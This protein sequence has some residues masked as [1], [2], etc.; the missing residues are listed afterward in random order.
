MGI[1]LE[2]EQAAGVVTA[3][4]RGGR[5]RAVARSRAVLLPV[6]LGLGALVLYISGQIGGAT[7]LLAGFSIA[8]VSFTAVVFR[9]RPGDE[10]QHE[11]AE[12]SPGGGDGPER[13]ASGGES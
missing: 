12:T 9:E 4:Q 11:A 6:V 10:A 7:T 2:Y 1:A 3:K 8:V 13:I 5:L